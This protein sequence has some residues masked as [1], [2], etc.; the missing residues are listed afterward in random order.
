MRAKL[1]EHY[2]SKITVSSGVVILANTASTILKEFHKNS[3]AEDTETEKLRIIKT[4]AKLIVSDIKKI[5]SDKD[6]F[7]M[8][9]EIYD[10]LSYLPVSLIHF[11]E[12]IY[13]NK[14]QR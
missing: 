12:T 1:Y 3:Q 9:D 11:L 5:M 7:P 10:S 14:L 2:G 13:N 4:A 8:S 6:H